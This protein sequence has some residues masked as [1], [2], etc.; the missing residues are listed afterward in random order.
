MTLWLKPFWREYV[1]IITNSAQVKAVSLMF[2]KALK[3]GEPRHIHS[4]ERRGRMV[5]G[6]KRGTN[7]C[8][9]CD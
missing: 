2:L 6:E 5:V 9:K 3:G 1:F 7:D 4:S 8:K